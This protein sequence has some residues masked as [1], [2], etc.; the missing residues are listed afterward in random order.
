MNTAMTFLHG[1]SLRADG[2]KFLTK[3][4]PETVP[5]A[6]QVHPLPLSMRE[7]HLKTIGMSAFD[8]SYPAT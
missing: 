6:G 3:L 5:F 1:W 8:N 7:S 4:S 2:E